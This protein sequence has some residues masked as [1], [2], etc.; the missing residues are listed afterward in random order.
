[1]PPSEDY[2]HLHVM[3]ADDDPA[4]RL[5]MRLLLERLGVGRVVLAEDGRQAVERI[6]HV[7]LLLLDVMMP[8][9][10]GVEVAQQLAATG[11]RGGVALVTGSTQSIRDMAGL[12]AKSVGLRY[13]GTV[14]KPI[15][16]DTLRQLLASLEDG[17]E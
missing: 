17:D 6:D 5:H 4:L 8:S 3:V 1:M 9:M 13:L 14:K 12:F 11:F 7:D 10:D 15:E 16:L 2:S